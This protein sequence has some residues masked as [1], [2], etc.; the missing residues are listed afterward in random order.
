ME[1]EVIN[2][3]TKWSQDFHEAKGAKFFIPESSFLNSKSNNY[4]SLYLND[5]VCFQ[6]ILDA[7]PASFGSFSNSLR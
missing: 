4:N 7:L 5:A 6:D 1:H 3:R 2:T